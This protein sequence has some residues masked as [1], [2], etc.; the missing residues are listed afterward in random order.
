MSSEQ[1]IDTCGEQVAVIDRELVGMSAEF[2]GDWDG[3]GVSV[4]DDAEEF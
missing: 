3:A 2:V 1:Q 4:P